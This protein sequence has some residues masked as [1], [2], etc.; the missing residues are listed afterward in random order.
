LHFRDTVEPIIEKSEEEIVLI[1]RKSMI[2]AIQYR[3][4]CTRIILEKAP[5]IA[6]TD[7]DVLPAGDD[8]RGRVE[9]RIDIE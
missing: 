4:A 7:T 9:L 8:E 5:G 1:D 3:K 6:I 2:G